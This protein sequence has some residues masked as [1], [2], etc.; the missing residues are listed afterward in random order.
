MAIATLGAVALDCPDP[1]ALAGF[2]G[3]VLGWE[4]DA[5][6]DNNSWVELKGPHGQVLAF[7]RSEGY[8]PPDWPGT[9]H[10]QQLHLDLDVRRENLEEAERRVLELGARLLEGDEGKRNWRVYADPVGHPFCLCF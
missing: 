2:Y 3:A 10:G 1:R 7:Q 8:R 9:E 5:E 6:P 4:L